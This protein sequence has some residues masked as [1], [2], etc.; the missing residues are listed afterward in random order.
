MSQT[1]TETDSFGPLEVPSDKYWGAQTQ[2]SIKTVVPMDIEQQSIFVTCLDALRHPGQLIWGGLEYL[3]AWRTSRR[4]WSMAFFSL[5]VII[6]ICVFSVAL[7][8]RIRR[9]VLLEQYLVWVQE[10][11]ELAEQTKQEPEEL[12]LS[13]FTL[14]VQNTCN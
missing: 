8:G 7:F 5:P 14:F 1:R 9:P 3:N 10:R 11:V 2:R 6:A 12:L 13:R 4:W